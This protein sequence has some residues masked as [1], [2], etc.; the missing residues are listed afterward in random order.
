MA[1]LFVGYVVLKSPM[2]NS[3]C[4]LYFYQLWLHAALSSVYIS[5][6][7]G[8]VSWFKSVSLPHPPSPDYKMFGNHVL[9]HTYIEL[10]EWFLE[11]SQLARRKSM[12]A[13]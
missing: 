5:S 11:Y 4:I 8:W 7:E 1:L 6:Y 9:I 2:E 13:V 10:S 12:L 3:L